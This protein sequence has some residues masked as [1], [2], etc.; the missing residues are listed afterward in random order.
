MSL[1][2]LFYVK[3]YGFL[4]FLKNIGKSMAKNISKNLNE[5][6]SQK[7][8]GHAKQAATDKLKTTS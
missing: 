1:E 4:S 6:S 8:F 5:S 7:H 2:I 3:A